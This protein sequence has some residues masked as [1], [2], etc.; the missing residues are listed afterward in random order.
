M[1]ESQREKHEDDQRMKKK[2]MDQD[3]RKGYDR[4]EEKREGLTSEGS[5]F[6]LSDGDGERRS[7]SV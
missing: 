4:W 1:N 6:C 2:E 5:S 7:R 3:S